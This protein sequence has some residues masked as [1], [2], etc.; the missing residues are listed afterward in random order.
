[1]LYGNRLGVLW[2]SVDDAETW[3][4]LGALPP[5]SDARFWAPHPSDPTVLFASTRDGVEKSEDG[6]KTWTPVTEYPLLAAFPFRLLIDPRA[7][8]TL[9]LVCWMRQPLRLVP[10]NSAAK[11]TRWM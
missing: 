5:G 10:S 11:V 9:Y 2:R 6:G 8:D 3:Q 4:P 7:P 1:V